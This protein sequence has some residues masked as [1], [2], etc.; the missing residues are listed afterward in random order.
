[1]KLFGDNIMRFENDIIYH[2]RE[3]IRIRSIRSMPAEGMPYGRDI[4]EALRYM[5]DLGRKLGFETKNID[6]YA[7]HAEYGEGEKVIGVLV[8]LD[9]VPE[10]SGWTHPP[11]EGRVTGGRIYGRG[12][13]DNKGPAVVALYSLKTLKDSGILP[14]RRVRVIFGTNEE[15]GM[16]DMAHYFSKE[17]CPV[18]AFSPDAGYPIFNREKG[19]M[20]LRIT[21]PKHSLASVRY[22]NGGIAANVV[23]DFCEAQIAACEMTAAELFILNRL[24]EKQ[25]TGCIINIKCESENIIITARGKQAH[26]SD[27]ATGLNAISSLIAFIFSA[28]IISGED[29]LLR[30]INDKINLETNGSLLG[31]ACNDDESGEL[32]LNLGMIAADVTG[33]TADLDIRYP[34]TFSGKQLLDRIYEQLDTCGLVLADF[35]D[36]PP[37]FMNENHPLIRIL[38]SAYEKVT[39]KKAGLLSLSGGTY[40]RMLRNRCVAFGSADGCNVH[41]PDEFVTISGLMG[42]AR[43]CTQALYELAVADLNDTGDVCL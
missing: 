9:V 22:I 3:I 28:G 26:A 14:D 17:P 11:Y 36:S 30:F 38:S 43:I 18:M 20:R 16:D 25:Q 4:S 13:A 37:L 19:I 27:P 5:L 8:H 40:A 6:G 31:I 7:G 10:G 15:N 35:Y 42:H 2:L 1:M 39:S 23:P 24:A 41:Q 33:G 34:V 29:T 21:S 12:A 32:T